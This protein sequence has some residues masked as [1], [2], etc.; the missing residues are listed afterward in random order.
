MLLR[1]LP[2]L[3]AL[4]A[5]PVVAADAAPTTGAD[6][7][8]LIECRG[9]IADYARSM[10]PLLSDEAAVKAAGWTKLPSS[11]RF[12]VEFKLPAPVSV[13]DAS[14][15]HLMIAGGSIMAILDLADPRPLAKRLQL[16][17]GVDTPEKFMAGREVASRDIVTPGTGETMIESVILSVSTVQSHP[18]KTLAGCTYDLD[19]P[20]PT[21]QSASPAAPATDG[22]D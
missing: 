18:G 4:P 21:E 2:L 17:D 8:A 16:E 3:L 14:T 15:D 11:N 5:L 1:L 20:E 13:F 6:L 7:P 22:K 10:V 19:Q 12:M 9:T